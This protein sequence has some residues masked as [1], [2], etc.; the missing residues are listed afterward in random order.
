MDHT[1][2]I[3]IMTKEKEF[4]AFFDGLGLKNFTAKEIIPYFKRSR[5]TFP[6]SDT[7]KNC[8][9]V[10]HIVD[11]LRDHFGKPVTIVSS[12][13]SPSYNRKVGGA[14]KSYHMEFLALDFKV[15][16]VSPQKVYNVLKKWRDAGLFKG[17]L[18]KYSTFVHIDTRGRNSSW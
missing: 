2:T 16:G 10:F 6:P 8:V 5:N 12:Y 14:S 17:G 18:K 3:E 9:R 11:A 15:S 7:W 1:A 13:R 4:K